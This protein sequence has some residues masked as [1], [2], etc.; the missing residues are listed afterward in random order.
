[1][2]NQ[3]A[4]P[5]MES[6][7]LSALAIMHNALHRCRHEDMRTADVAAA[8]HFLAD[9]W[10]PNGLSASFAKPW[11]VII[12][13][14][15]HR[16]IVRNVIESAPDDIKHRIVIVPRGSPPATAGRGCTWP[17]SFLSRAFHDFTLFS[18]RGTARTSPPRAARRGFMSKTSPAHR[19]FL[20][21]TFARH[22]ALSAVRALPP[23]SHGTRRCGNY[24]IT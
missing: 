7:A 14:G 24:V 20:D 23:A 2:T 15:T 8:L 13:R 9:R 12:A 1:M 18:V 19:G 5:G 11:K 21:K 4:R 6:R 17:L 10:I 22:H 3:R 16:A